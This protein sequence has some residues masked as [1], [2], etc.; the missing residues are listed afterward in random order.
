MYLKRNVIGLLALGA[1]WFGLTPQMLAAQDVDHVEMEATLT[2]NGLCVVTVDNDPKSQAGTFMVENDHVVVVDGD[3]V[4]RVTGH[5]EPAGEFVNRIECE[6]LVSGTGV[7]D[8]PTG[9]PVGK[10]AANPIEPGGDPFVLTD[11]A[12]LLEVGASG[13]FALE[14]TLEFY[15][16][17]SGLSVSGPFVATATFTTVVA[18]D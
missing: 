4:A 11:E 16:I 3:S 17:A 8:L 18:I 9:T 15:G 7:T 6:V 1:L 10:V 14:M 12:R 2:Q 13:D 5:V